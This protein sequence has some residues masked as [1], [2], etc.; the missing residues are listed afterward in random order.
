MEPGPDQLE[1]RTW[2][3]TGGR[4]ARPG[5]P[6]NAPLVPASNYVLGD[7]L[8]YAPVRRHTDLACAR[9]AHRRSRRR[10]RLEF[11]KRAGG[12]GRSV[13][14]APGVGRRW[15]S[16]TTATTVW[17][18]SP[19]TAHVEADG[20][21]NGSRCP[22][23]DR[24]FDALRRA[25]LVWLESP[26]NPMLQLADLDAIGSAPRRAGGLLVVDNTFATPLN[27]RPLARGADLSMLSATKHLGGHSDLLAGGDHDPRRCTVRCPPPV[28]DHHRGDARRPRSVPRS[29]GRP[30]AR[31]P[32][33]NRRAQR[34]RDR[35]PLG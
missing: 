6:L 8:G 30:H 31:G 27:Q 24:W 7:E 20:R 33:R 2:V 25:D 29:A 22:T 32:S 26:S 3:V 23:P 15:R 18:T 12:G 19:T 1:A 13:R 10:S 14:P 4:T 5:D 21:S 28:T 34:A 11:R 16:P 35:R 17:W 9:R